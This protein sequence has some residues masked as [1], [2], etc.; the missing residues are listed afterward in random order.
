MANGAID[1]ARDVVWCHCPVTPVP[2]PLVSQQQSSAGELVPLCWPL[3][4]GSWGHS[5][6][7][8]HCSLD[9]DGCSSPAGSGAQGGGSARPWRWLCAQGNGC[10]WPWGRQTGFWEGAMPGRSTL[11]SWQGWEPLPAPG[12]NSDSSSHPTL[13]CPTTQ[14]CGTAGVCMPPLAA[15]AG[16]GCQ[17]LLNGARVKELRVPSRSLHG[18]LP[19]DTGGCYIAVP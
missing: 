12:D 2:E 1:E 10:G 13:S 18:D 6:G 14:G 5:T 7:S 8:P 3:I 16:S 4:Q 11:P 19:G 9:G 15:R 17:H